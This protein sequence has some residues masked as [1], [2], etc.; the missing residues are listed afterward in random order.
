MDAHYHIHLLHNVTCSFLYSLFAPHSET[1]LCQE[2]SLAQIALI[3]GSGFW[4]VLL[5]AR[6]LF[7]L[8]SCCQQKEQVKER[9]AQKKKK[10]KQEEVKQQKGCPC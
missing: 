1:L 5:Y 10:K 7:S 2:P 8:S 4:S 9:E 6:S 3:L